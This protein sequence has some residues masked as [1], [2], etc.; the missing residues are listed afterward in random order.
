MTDRRPPLVTTAHGRLRGRWQG[1]VAGFLGIP[2]AAPPVGRGRFAPPRPVRP[3]TGLRDA[4]RPGPAAPQPP[5]RLARVMG[6]GDLACAE[7]C[8]SLN[9]WTPEPGGPPRPVLVFV[10]GGGFLT[11]SGG[12]DW[13]DGAELALRGGIVV[14][15]IN[16]R[17]GALGFLHLGEL[18]EDM[19][20]G[21]LGLLDQIHALRWVREH[22]AAF[23]GDP[24]TVTVCGQSAGAT[25]IL[26]MLSA[27]AGRG[28]F[29]RAIVQSAP[30]GMR[31]AQPAEATG[32]ATHF[33]RLLGLG[34]D[35]VGL[36]RD[37]PV[38]DILVAQQELAALT[39]RH[40]F[41]AT[42]PF[43]LVADG[44]TVAEDPV[45]AVGARAADGVALVIGTTRDEAAA[46]FA[47]DDRVA[48]MTTAEVRAI[49]AEW[50]GDRG[51][52]TLD[53]GTGPAELAV[54]VVTEHLFRAPSVRLAEL[55]AANGNP[56]R[57]YQFDWSP[58][59]GPFRACH[60]IEL[61]FVFGNL[62]A[63]RDAP[64]LAGGDPG[65]QQAIVESVQ[66]RW[67]SFVRH[68]DPLPERPPRWPTYDKGRR[69]VLHFTEP[70]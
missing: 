15:T 9:V 23:G 53:G 24:D 10:H 5:S 1:E 11:G 37:V 63:W 60:C 62:P 36:L 12:L 3:W 4:S 42:P 46:F 26:G 44:D 50:F 38:A 19:G 51:D 20:N 66:E 52:P 49:A 8:L 68:G 43:Q 61:P 30:G 47:A 22:I 57:L 59:T 2:Y 56:G 40:P 48:R 32:L 33:L 6:P 69:S 7:D 28:L 35:Q 27:P 55:L 67:I 58:E 13:Y 64:M 29:R 16:Y 21:N 65:V 18:A 14:V 39:R 54:E 45:A 41:D 25:S 17:L 34:P 70:H 31:P